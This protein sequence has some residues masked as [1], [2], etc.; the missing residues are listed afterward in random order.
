MELDTESVELEDLEEEAEYDV[1]LLQEFD[2]EDEDDEK[3][4]EEQEEEGVSGAE[5]R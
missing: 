1:L 3:G 5:E 2:V 4:K